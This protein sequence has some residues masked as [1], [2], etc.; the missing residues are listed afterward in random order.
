MF[1][2]VADHLTGDYSEQ[3]AQHACLDMHRLE[4]LYFIQ[5]ADLFKCLFDEPAADVLQLLGNF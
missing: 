1:G 5:Q 3:S 4:L 2:L